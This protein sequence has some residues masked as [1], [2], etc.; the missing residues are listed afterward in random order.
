MYNKINYFKSSFIHIQLTYIIIKLIH[1]LMPLK[2]TRYIHSLFPPIFSRIKLSG[3][4]INNGK[5]LLYLTID[6]FLEMIQS[7]I[8]C[9]QSHPLISA[10]YRIPTFLLKIIIYIL[11]IIRKATKT[12]LTIKIIKNY[13]W[14]T[15]QLNYQF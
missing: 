12:I 6:K 13:R 14:Y 10:H 8:I 2:Y 3:I 5:N 1:H 15:Y 9:A 7:F 4:T 11:Y